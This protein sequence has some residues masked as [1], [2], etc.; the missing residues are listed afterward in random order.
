[1]L[2][3][4]FIFLVKHPMY[5]KNYQIQFDCYSPGTLSYVSLI[6]RPSQ[7]PYKAEEK[8]YLPSSSQ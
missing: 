1:M 2:L 5:M 7:R 6:L 8:F 4:V 3:W